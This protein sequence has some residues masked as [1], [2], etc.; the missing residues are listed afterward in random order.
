MDIINKIISTPTSSDDL[1][2]IA[3]KKCNIFEYNDL[4]KF[5]SLDSLFTEGNS[6]IES[7][8]NLNLPFCDNT[9]IMLYKSTPNFG[10]WT[11]L[12]KNET[13]YN[14][15][16]SYGDVIDSQLS[17]IDPK[18]LIESG[19]DKKYLVN[20]LLGTDSDIY[21]NNTKMQKLGDKVSSC[22]LY[23]AVY[24]KYNF[25]N[26]DEFAAWIKKLGKKYKFSS[27]Q[28]IALLSIF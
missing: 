26:V 1:F 20:L 22:G 14:F 17:H 13:G 21:Y 4:S 6:K 2:N 15:L 16:D 10:H 12:V 28:I 11:A 5:N 7:S 3:G 24:L 9:C 18:F 8:S 27:D 23:C 25:M 19:Q